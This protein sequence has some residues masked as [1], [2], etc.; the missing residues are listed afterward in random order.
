MLTKPAN[1]GFPLVLSVALSGA[2]AFGAPAWAGGKGPKDDWKAAEKARKDFYKYQAKG[3]VGY[4]GYGVAP[5]AIPVVPSPSYGVPPSYGVGG[6]SPGNYA[7]LGPIGVYPAAPSYGANGGYAP[8]YSIYNSGPVGAPVY[9][10]RYPTYGGG[11]PTYGGYGYPP[12][13]GITG[14]RVDYSGS[15]IWQ[16]QR[17][18][19]PTPY[20]W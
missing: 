9:A 16:G 17:Y 1:G 19:A 11:Y 5:A 8:G 6:I 15:L 20:P 14:G 3:Q 13:T 4:P 10:G 2:M 18:A 7:P 12:P